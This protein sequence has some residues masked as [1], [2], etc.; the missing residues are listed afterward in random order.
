MWVKSQGN[1]FTRCKFYIGRKTKHSVST[2][3]VGGFGLYTNTWFHVEDYFS[4][5][6]L[7]NN[8]KD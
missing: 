7:C 4:N 6:L 3:P 8:L 1:A 2:V 5:L